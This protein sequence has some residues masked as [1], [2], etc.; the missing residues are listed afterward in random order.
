MDSEDQWRTD[1]AQQGNTQRAAAKNAA[2]GRGG[3]RA[4][5][6][7]GGVEGAKNGALA[8]PRRPT[9]ELETT[10]QRVAVDAG[11]GGFEQPKPAT[12]LQIA[13]RR[14]RWCGKDANS[15]HRNALSEPR[16]R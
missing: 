14:P 4:G 13:S 3:R 16:R 2:A 15:T 7:E 10:L 11:M 5:L 1:E 12:S 6:V 8:A 9:R